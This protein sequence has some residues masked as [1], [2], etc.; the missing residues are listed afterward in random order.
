MA[1]AKKPRYVDVS[2]PSLSVD[3]PRCG[4]RTARFTDHC[5][6][7]GYKLWPSSVMASAAFKAWRAAE[8]E[9]R[10][11]VSRFDLSLPVVVDDLVDY[12]ARA[13]ELGIHIFPN[14]NWP[15]TICFGALFLG[16]A[17]IPFPAPARIA[18]L[19]VGGL[20][21]LVGVVGWVVVEDVRMFPT[22]AGPAGGEHHS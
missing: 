9:N 3:C 13:H 5:R 6:N 8:P 18:L 2:N 19:V 1:K 17:A 12:D 14:S 20:I 10:A 11:G 7:C 15:F 22:D 4:L 16:L 21:F